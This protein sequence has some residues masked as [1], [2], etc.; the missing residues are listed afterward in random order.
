M[1][2][3]R[4]KATPPSDDVITSVSCSSSSSIHV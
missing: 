1:E 2:G 4:W 3:W